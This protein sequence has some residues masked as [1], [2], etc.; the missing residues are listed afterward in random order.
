MERSVAQFYEGENDNPIEHVQEFHA[1]MQQL[2]IHHEDILMKMFMYSLDGD[3]H[4][5]YYSLP[6]SNISSLK[7]F[8][9]VFNEHYKRF[10]PSES[11]C[12]NCCEGYVEY[13][14]DLLDC[15]VEYKDENHVYEQLEAT[16]T[17]VPEMD[18]FNS[19]ILD[20][21]IVLEVDHRY[22]GQPFFDEYSSD[23]EKQAYPIFDHYEDREDDAEVGLVT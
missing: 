22:E 20:E 23:D 12:H 21:I 6:P 7:E 11:I 14:E 2:D 13:F 8:H 9:R 17:V 19:Y 1:L 5:W 16:V 15:S 18:I 4:K 10:Y 3:A